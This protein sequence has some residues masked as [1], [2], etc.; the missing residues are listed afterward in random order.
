VVEWPCGE[1]VL[2]WDENRLVVLVDHLG[3]F[4]L[5]GSPLWWEHYLPL[6]LRNRTPQYLAR[7]GI[8]TTSFAA[9]VSTSQGTH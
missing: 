2:R 6:D 5:F 8:K 3:D 9:G 7:A 1:C 4:A